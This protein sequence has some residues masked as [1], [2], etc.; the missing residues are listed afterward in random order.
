[1]TEEIIKDKISV[2]SIVALALAIISWILLALVLRNVGIAFSEPKDRFI[3]DLMSSHMFLM[4]TPLIFILAG[5]ALGIL[6]LYRTKEIRSR[7]T[8]WAAIVLSGIP[9]LIL[10]IA[11]IGNPG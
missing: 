4:Y 3:A 6:S 1:M 11:I 10:I 8:S 5:L 2:L 7:V 9:I